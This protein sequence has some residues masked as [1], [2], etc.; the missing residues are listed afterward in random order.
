M[1]LFIESSNNYLQRNLIDC[2]LE[3]KMELQILCR[4][5]IKAK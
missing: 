2:V 4:K 5:K 1:N 3:T